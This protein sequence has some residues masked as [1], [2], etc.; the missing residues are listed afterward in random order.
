V[1]LDGESLGQSRA[2]ALAMFALTI[3]MLARVDDGR[4]AHRA[5]QRGPGMMRCA[6][7]RRD[8]AEEPRSRMRDIPSTASLGW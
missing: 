5:L 8:A 7:G 3:A 4:R 1:S 6:S 2:P